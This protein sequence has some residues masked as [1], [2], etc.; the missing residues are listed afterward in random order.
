ML[1]Q[2]VPEQR[3]AKTGAKS[4]KSAKSPIQ[5]SPAGSAL[6]DTGIETAA[7]LWAC[8]NEFC[9]FKELMQRAVS[10]PEPIIDDGILW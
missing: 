3:A 2:E 10:M 5:P 7:R 1:R 6:P 8:S 9:T 4:H